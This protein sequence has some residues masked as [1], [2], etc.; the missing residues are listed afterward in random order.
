MLVSATAGLC[1]PHDF[2][3]R[4]LKKDATNR[5]GG[6]SDSTP[7]GIG[8]KAQSENDH[9]ERMVSICKKCEKTA[10]ELGSPVNQKCCGVT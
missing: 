10:G 6:I 7:V 2:E 8:L 9:G 1:P 5:N 3:V 4:V